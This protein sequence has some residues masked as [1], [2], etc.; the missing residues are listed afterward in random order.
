MPRPLAIASFACLLSFATSAAHATQEVPTDAASAYRIV[1]NMRNEAL[2]PLRKG[3]VN[4]AEFAAA[5]KKID[6]V[7]QYLQTPL[8][9]DLSNGDKFLRARRF[10][11]LLEISRYYVQRGG[12]A[13]IDK[14]LTHLETAFGEITA[15]PLKRMLTSEPAFAPLQNEPRLQALLQKLESTDRLWGV[16]TI[17]SAYKE[18][19][20]VEERVAGLSLFWAEARQNFVHFDKVPALAWDQLYLDTLK[21]VMAAETT[22][23][24]Y[25]VLMRFAPKLRDGHTNIYPPKELSQQF[26]ARP[27]LLT[28]LIEGKVIV[29]RVDS[30]SLAKRIAIGDEVIAI[31]GQSAIKYAE[32]KVAPYV[33]SSTPQDR[34]LR[35]YSYQLLSGD[36]ANPI[37]LTLR[38]AQG[39]ERVERVSRAPITDAS[40]AIRP[41]RFGFNVTPEGVAVISIDHFESDAG[42]KAFE[43][44][45]PEIMRAKGLVIDLRRNGGG[46]TNFGLAILSYLTSMPIHGS[47]SFI[48]SETAL[49]RARGENSVSWLDI[50]S[51]RPFERK[52]EQIFTGPVA[53]LTSAQTFSAAEDFMVSYQMLK[54]GV[55]V[56]TATGGSTGQ[57][58]FIKL[59]GGGSGR[60]CV[61]RDRFPD[62]REFVGVGI[63]P[64]IEAKRTVAD[65][66]AGRDPE[67]ARAVE[68]VLAK[69]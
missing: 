48:R 27:P 45:L 31:D 47:A 49:D 41:E 14:A 33:S 15:P 1:E 20:S 52:R 67:L 54:R 2:A 28:A 24:Y 13:N 9:R 56:G 57:P 12:A 46:S 6:G 29:T 53:V 43:K 34:D 7:L 44:A 58:L 69:R 30:S 16:P 19:L 36:V 63:K 42:V 61:K 4:D 39:K 35:T 38:D 23:D 21:Q 51:N 40:D 55:T 64:D 66:R 25:D 8:I 68:V 62:G 10:N 17:A 22:R 11:T 37:A 65:V 3:E 59:P 5:M 18:K 60:I 50:S 32:E 26:Y